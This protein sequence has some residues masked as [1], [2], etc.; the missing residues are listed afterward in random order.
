MDDS[1][2]KNKIYELENRI[3]KLEQINSSEDDENSVISFV[4]DI[5]NIRRLLETILYSQNGLR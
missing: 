4:L 2:F 3:N 5:F 1:S